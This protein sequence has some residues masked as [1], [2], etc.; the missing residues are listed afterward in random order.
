MRTPC[1]AVNQTRVDGLRHGL[2]CRVAVNATGG[3]LGQEPGHR[4]SAG[5]P[6]CPHS[7]G[8]CPLDY[9]QKQALE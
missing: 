8:T 6:K 5:G 9:L 7:L 1:K 3:I 2:L 4:T